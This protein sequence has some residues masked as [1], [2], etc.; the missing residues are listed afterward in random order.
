MQKA[1]EPWILHLCAQTAS[2]VEESIQVVCGSVGV[3]RSNKLENMRAR[4]VEK[5]TYLKNSLQFVGCKVL[6]IFLMPDEENLGGFSQMGF[7]II[8]YVI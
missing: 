7:H 1:I 5:K 4:R 2:K 6:P 3:D 8:S